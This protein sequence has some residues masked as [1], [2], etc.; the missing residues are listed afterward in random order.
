MCNM[1]A[2][3]PFYVRPSAGQNLLCLIFFIAGERENLANIF[4]PIRIYL[5]E[6]I[7]SARCLLRQCQKTEGLIS[8][9]LQLSLI[10]CLNNLFASIRN[11]PV[12][13]ASTCTSSWM[14]ETVYL[15]T[16]FTLWPR[17]GCARRYLTYHLLRER[18]PQWWPLGLLW[19]RVLVG[20]VSNSAGDVLAAD[21]STGLALPSRLRLVALLPITVG[22]LVVTKFLSIHVA[23]FL[24]ASLNPGS[25]R[26]ASE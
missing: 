18:R 23:S 8:P 10:R 14:P 6:H 9:A 22:F 1:I 20:S 25:R 21:V 13:T 5:L 7:I 11:A 3:P 16:I 26:T 2:Y 17:C 19:L 12:P 15:I 4:P 24:Y